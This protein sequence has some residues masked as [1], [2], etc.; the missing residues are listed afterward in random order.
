MLNIIYFAL[1][2]IICTGYSLNIAVDPI[3]HIVRLIMVLYWIA[4]IVPT[5]I[6]MIRKK[7]NP[8]SAIILSIKAGKETRW[9]QFF[10]A[11]FIFIL[12][13]VGTAL[14]GLGL[15]VTIPLSYVLLE[16]YYLQ[17]DEFE[18]FKT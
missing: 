2:K 17:M 11:V 18:L 16:R 4:I 10:I 13:I 1:L 6:L 14:V 3:L 9:Q 15:L 5:P 8:I 12:N 7:M